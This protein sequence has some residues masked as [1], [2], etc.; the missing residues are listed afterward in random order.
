[1]AVVA[2]VVDLAA[3]NKSIGHY[4]LGKNLG[5]GTFGTVRYGTHILTGERVAVKVPEKDRIKEAADVERVSREMRILKLVKHPHVIQLYE[6][7]ETPRQLY[8]IMEFASG[9]EL[10]DYIVSH[11]RVPER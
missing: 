2:R 8:L 4:L 5:E 9:G 10:F 3:K 1:M 7:I 11:Q 6:I